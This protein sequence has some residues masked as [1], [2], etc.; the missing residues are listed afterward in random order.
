MSKAWHLCYIIDMKR[1]DALYDLAEGNFGLVSFAQAKS[2][3]V[4]IRELDRWLKNGWLERPA[5]GLYRI[6]RFPYSDR[7]PYAIAVESVG[8]DAYLQGE[9]VLALLDLV[10]T[11]PNWIYVGTPRRVRRK[12]DGRVIV[13]REAGGCA[14]ANYFG[15]RSQR[16]FDALL[17]CASTV[18]A[19]R[20]LRAS[21]EGLRLGYLNKAEYV[22]VTKEIG[23]AQASA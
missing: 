12:V 13:M 19:S 4:S 18:S 3:G 23:R 11:N 8:N 5:R 14:R 16:L 15:I 6:S 22:R 1:F 21:K 2:L 17:S 10:P 9:S 7:D 20:R